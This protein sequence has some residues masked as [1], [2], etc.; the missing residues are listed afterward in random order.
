MIGAAPPYMVTETLA[1]DSIAHKEIT[2]P[3]MS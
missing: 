2:M 3:E 1:F